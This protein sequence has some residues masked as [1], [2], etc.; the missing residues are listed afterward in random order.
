MHLTGYRQH[1]TIAATHRPMFTRDERQRDAD[2]RDTETVMHLLHSC[3]VTFAW[4]HDTVG[5]PQEQRSGL[6]FK[7]DRAHPR[8]TQTASDVLRVALP[9]INHYLRQRIWE[10]YGAI[11]LEQSYVLIDG[12]QLLP[13]DDL[14]CDRDLPDTADGKDRQILAP[15]SMVYRA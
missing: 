13:L 2:E 9:R 8:W 5:Q 7:V 4:K 12:Q 1:R 3:G 6:C 14:S 15:D 11:G 10:Q